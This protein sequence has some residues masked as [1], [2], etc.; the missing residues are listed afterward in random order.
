MRLH[1]AEVNPGVRV[2]SLSGWGDFSQLPPAKCLEES[3]L[4]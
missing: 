4:P 3:L 1:E 2:Y